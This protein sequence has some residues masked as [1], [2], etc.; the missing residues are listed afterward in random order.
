MGWSTETGNVRLK[1]ATAELERRLIQ[2]ALDRNRNNLSRT[3]VELG[4]SRRGLR[5][6]LGQLGINRE[7]RA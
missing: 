6:K 2:E 7:Q 3:A 1:V 4:L 5:L